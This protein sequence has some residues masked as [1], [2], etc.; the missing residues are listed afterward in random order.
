M[1]PVTLFQA[2][3]PDFVSFSLALSRLQAEFAD[4]VSNEPTGMR[5]R[6]NDALKN[7]Q[8]SGLKCVR[9]MRIPAHTGQ[10]QRE[11]PPVDL[12]G[13]F[14]AFSAYF[15]ANAQPIKEQMNQSLNEGQSA[16]VAEME[17]LGKK[18]GLDLMTTST[19]AAAICHDQNIVTSENLVAIRALQDK[20]DDLDRIRLNAELE[21]AELLPFRLQATLRLAHPSPV[22]PKP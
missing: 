1:A 5:A 8:E 19:V 21:I 17:Q 9:D 2:K 12:K 20:I 13:A 4:A 10:Q 18:L 14:P 11:R 7:L 6:F 16:I 3:V 15:A 22:N